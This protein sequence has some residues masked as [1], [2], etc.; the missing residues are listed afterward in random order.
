MKNLKE[1]NKTKFI[2]EHDR[3]LKDVFTRLEN[4]ELQPN[5]YLEYTVP[6]YT[7][8][9]NFYENIAISQLGRFDG[10][11]HEIKYEESTDFGCDKFTNRAHFHFY[12]L[13]DCKIYMTVYEQCGSY[14]FHYVFKG[15]ESAREKYRNEI[16]TMFDEMFDTIY[17]A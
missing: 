16:V 4:N 10:L 17:D 12:E 11:L 15:D 6:M 7:N 5:E 1:L 2:Q 9:G 14:I 13:K 3:V 8:Y